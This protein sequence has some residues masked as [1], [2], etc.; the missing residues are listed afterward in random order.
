MVRGKSPFWFEIVGFVENVQA[1]GDQYTFSR[2]PSSVLAN[3]MKVLKED[4]KRWNRMEFG[5][6]GVNKKK[7][8]DKLARLDEKEGVHGL[9]HEERRQREEMKVEV[10]CLVSL[11][12]ISW[13]QKSR[14][15][16]LKEGD[17]NT[18]FFHN[19]ANLHRR[20]NHLRIYLSQ[21]CSLPSQPPLEDLPPPLRIVKTD[22][23]LDDN[24][25]GVDLDKEACLS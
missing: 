21:P 17:N 1:W 19:M 4:L 15:L 8:L 14:V 20:Y 12:E 22:F 3:K 13:R 5:N 16:W 7:L 25:I 6:V 24:E 23:S 18:K 10:E 2:T 9:M 11:E